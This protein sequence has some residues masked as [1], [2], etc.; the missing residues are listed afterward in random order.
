MKHSLLISLLLLAPAITLF[1]ADTM[2]PPLEADVIF[3]IGTPDAR[4]AEFALVREGYAAFPQKFPNGVFYEVGKST[5]ENDWSFVHPSIQDRHW[6]GGKETHPFTIRFNSDEDIDDPTTLVIGYMGTHPDR[7]TIHVVANETVLPTQ[8]PTHIGHDQAVF[9]PRT[10]RGG[11]ASNLFTIPAGTFKKGENT[12]TITLVGR[13]WILYDYVALRREAQPLAIRERPPLD[14]LTQFRTWEDAPMAGINQIVFAVRIDNHEH[15]YANFGRTAECEFSHPYHAHDGAFHNMVKPTPAPVSGG[16]LGIFNLDTKEVHYILEDPTGSIRDPIVHYD[17][18][19]ILFSY[20]PGGTL[21]FHLYEINVDGTHLRQLTDGPFDDIEPTYTPEGRIVFVSS[22]ANRYVQCWMTQV[23]I[24]Y[25]CDADGQDI[26]LLSGNI[27]HD[28][29]PWMLPNGQILYMRWEYV[30]RSQVDFHHLW[31]MNPDGTRQMVFYG[32]MHPGV[33]YI[34]AKPIPNSEK[35]VASFSWGH[36]AAEHA[37][38]I[39]VID[40]RMGPDY[41]DAAVV[42]TSDSTFRDPWAFSETAF[43]AARRAQMVLVDGDG[44][45]Q[46][47]YELPEEYRQKS[48]WLHEPRPLVPRERERIISS[49]IDPTKSTGQLLVMDVHQGR[50]MEGVEVG[51]IKNLLILETLPKPINFTGGMEPMTYGGSF[52]LQRIVGIVPVEPDGSANFEL[53]ATRA[54]FFVA[55]DEHDRAVKRMQSFHTV[56]PGEVTTCIGCHEDRTEISTPFP[57]VTMASR[58]PPSPITPIADFRGICPVTGTLLATP[59]GIPD[60]I[61]YS[62]DVQ[63]IWD[64]HCIACHSP[65]KREGNFNLSGGRGPMYSVSYSNIMARTH[66]ALENERYGRETLVADGRNKPLG[67]YPPRT[68]GSSASALYTK[69][70]QNEHHGVELSEREK[71]IVRLWIETGA[72]YPGTYASLGSGMLGGYLRNTLDR[73]DLEWAETIAMQE[74]LR[75]NCASCH[76]GNRQLPLSVSDEIRHTWWIYPAGPHD[77]RRHYS[78]HLHFDLTYPEQSTLLL[79]PL[80]KSAG[81]LELCGD[82]IL[83]STDDPRYQAIL[84]GIVRAQQRLNEIKRFDMPDFV[85]RPEYIREM[86]AYGILP[87]DHDPTLAIDVYEL[88][89]RYWRSLWYVPV[90]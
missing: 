86:I 45:E 61:D 21:F 67:N 89:Q 43:L 81:G 56:M 44:N 29:T 33:V 58:R 8:L 85:P 26:Q 60:V 27:E 2:E 87:L 14:L 90:E 48:L 77:S 74:V 88:E 37:G 30:D 63:P 47:I 46:V 82:A 62:R 25:S 20:R 51:D 73:R 55:L 24:L 1:A 54:F 18:E 15:W 78:R 31:T 75:N 38:A 17:G 42:I 11:T 7:S 84:A 49:V 39:G 71:A 69:Y 70:I 28:N 13:S 53:P 40:P 3:C 19:K 22:R 65:D 4:G 16:K 32:N 66:S 9:R 12:I 50:N 35:I 52:T 76:T 57:R 80:A 41:R 83:T 6:A 59:T 34:G 5:P 79:A 72:T 10:Y 68:L 23:A 36:G 64:R